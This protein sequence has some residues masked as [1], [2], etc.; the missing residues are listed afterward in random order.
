MYIKKN[1]EKDFILDIFLLELF[2]VARVLETKTIGK[3]WKAHLF[4]AK[5]KTFN[6]LPIYIK[7]FIKNR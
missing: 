7:S 2:E 6:T 1:G 4:T 3:I 5:C